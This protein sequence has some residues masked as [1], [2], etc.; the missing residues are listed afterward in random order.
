MDPRSSPRGFK[1][2]EVASLAFLAPPG[3]LPNQSGFADRLL[4]CDVEVDRQLYIVAYH[5]RGKLAGNIEGSPAKGGS[6]GVTGMG[7]LVHP[8]D[9]SGRPL[10]GEHHRLCY[11][12]QGQVA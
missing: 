7:F 9:R 1:S 2:A 5:G 4:L 12:V 3:T 6:C 10:H 8:W 11:A